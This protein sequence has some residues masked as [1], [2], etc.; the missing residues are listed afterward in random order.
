MDSLQSR[1]YFAA[2]NGDLKVRPP[3]AIAPALGASRLTSKIQG[4][5]T[6]FLSLALSE[7]L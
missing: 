2:G 5:R 7:R 1:W 6:N 3:D 4:W